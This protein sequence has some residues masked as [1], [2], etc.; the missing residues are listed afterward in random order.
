MLFDLVG[1]AALLWGHGLMRS[2][3]LSYYGEKRTGALEARKSGRRKEA[4]RWIRK[5]EKVT[6]ERE[7]A[8]K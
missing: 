2:E 6:K 1:H 7:I 4:E 8:S 3:V 5:K